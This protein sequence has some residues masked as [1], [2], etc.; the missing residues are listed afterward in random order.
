MI[1]FEEFFEQRGLLIEQS[2]SGERVGKRV[3]WVGLC[4]QEDE[5]TDSQGENG[6]EEVRSL[7][8][9]P[10]RWHGERLRCEMSMRY[11]LHVVGGRVS[12]AEKRKVCELDER[13]EEREQIRGWS[14]PGVMQR[15]SNRGLSFGFAGSRPSSHTA[16]KSVCEMRVSQPA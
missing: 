4:S 1:S 11:W 10:R 14:G 5:E 3:V 13:R 16:H 12:A 2:S 6:D 9:H 7:H 8:L 15:C